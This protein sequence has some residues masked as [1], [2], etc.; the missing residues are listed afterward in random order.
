MHRLR[1]DTPAR[2]LVNLMIFICSQLAVRGGQGWELY[3]KWSTNGGSAGPGKEGDAYPGSPKKAKYGLASW[4]L[5]LSRCAV[6]IRELPRGSWS[7]S[8]DLEPAIVTVDL[9]GTVRSRGGPLILMSSPTSKCQCKDAGWV[10][11]V[12]SHGSSS[13]NRLRGFADKHAR[14]V[15]GRVDA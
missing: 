1:K 5:H 14:K 15:H 8:S 7:A 9:L 11:I 12:V 13:V 6:R 2:R 3:W 4:I 10:V